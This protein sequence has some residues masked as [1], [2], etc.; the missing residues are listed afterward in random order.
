MN[1]HQN[2][3][4]QNQFFQHQN[5]KHIPAQYSQTTYTQ[6]HNYLNNESHIPQ[7]Y[8]TSDVRS[9]QSH[10]INSN[11]IITTTQSPPETSHTSNYIIPTRS[12]RQ[13]NNNQNMKTLDPNN[14][15]FNNTK[16]VVSGNSSPTFDDLV[17]KS[18]FGEDKPKCSVDFDDMVASQFL[19]SPLKKVHKD[20]SDQFLMDESIVAPG[21]LDGLDESNCTGFNF[22]DEA[23]NV[24]SRIDGLMEFDRTN[25]NSGEKDIRQN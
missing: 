19:N 13:S 23:E 7:I 12:P 22:E 16:K 1:R 15:N 18:H 4:L 9:Y 17:M 6:N 20:S 2:N 10:Q 3:T 14:L 8:T 25:L 11:P 21:N 5:S 24:Q